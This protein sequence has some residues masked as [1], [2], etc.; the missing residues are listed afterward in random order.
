[1]D[2]LDILSQYGVDVDR[3]AGGSNVFL[4]YCP[5]HEEN[6]PSLGFDTKTGLWSCFGCHNGGSFTKLIAG[7]AGVSILEAKRELL[8]YESADSLIDDLTS[9]ME[10]LNCEETKKELKYLSIK[11]FH[12]LYLALDKHPR[13]MQYMLGRG[14][15]AET[16]REFDFRYGGDSGRWANRVIVPIYDEQGR[17]LSFTGRTLIKNKTPKYKNVKGRSNLHTLFGL[18]QLFGKY[19]EQKFKY[20]MVEEGG[21]DAS[22]LQQFGIYSVATTG[23]SKFTPHQVFLFKRYADMV[24]LNYDADAGGDHAF[25]DNER[26][27]KKYMPVVQFHIPIEGKDPND[28]TPSEVKK[29][30][31][32]FINAAV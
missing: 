10:S 23:T 7:Y 27:L 14:F 31:R 15:S 5:F 17:L 24:V 4:S 1:M 32:R 25:T 3:P 29:I 22:Y 19:G 20:L 8:K 12:A 2:Y 16:I 11:S 6:T 13:S 30:Y 21:L 28:L 9:S 26:L 18:Y